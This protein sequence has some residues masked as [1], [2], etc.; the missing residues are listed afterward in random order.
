MSKFEQNIVQQTCD[1]LVYRYLVEK[2]YFK[3]AELLKQERKNSYTLKAQKDEKVSGK[4]SYLISKH[5]Q[6]ELDSVSCNLVC[7]YMKKQENPK[8]QKLVL[9]LK[10]LVP[11][12][13]ITGKTPS[14]E[15]VLN[16][17]I[18]TRKILVPAKKNLSNQLP[19]QQKRQKSLMIKVSGIDLKSKAPTKNDVSYLFGS[20]E[21]IV[22][23]KEYL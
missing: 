12:I 20:G 6:M 8:I 13:Q 14:I 18:V 1:T 17:T 11:S 10:S 22:P 4:L 15:E 16:H 21:K 9:K 23:I 19:D 2:G 5:V 7:D 3:T